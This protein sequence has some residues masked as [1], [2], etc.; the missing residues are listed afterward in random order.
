MEQQESW[1]HKIRDLAPDIEDKEYQ[2]YKCEA[3]VKKLQA[4]LKL[5]ALGEG[6]KTTSAQETNAEASEELDKERLE[7][8]VAKGGL[9]A[10]KVNLKGLEIGFEEWRTKQVSARKERDR[11]G[12]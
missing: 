11:Y 5:E 4:Q 12:A 3:E 8:G 7:V 2:V 9:S 6:I 1:M 10:L